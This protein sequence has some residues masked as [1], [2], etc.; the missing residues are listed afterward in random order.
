MTTN[1]YLPFINR[2]PVLTKHSPFTVGSLNRSENTYIIRWRLR[3]FWEGSI[4]F[5]ITN[6]QSGGLHPC[7]IIGCYWDHCNLGR[8]AS[9][10]P[11]QGAG[12]GQRHRVSKQS[13]AARQWIS[14]VCERLQQLSSLERRPGRNFSG[15][16]RCALG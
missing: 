11:Q 7:R 6:T 5:G 13:T 14:P 1:Y 4:E 15:W 9:S 3:A 12:T 2:L 16:S 10:G 8:S